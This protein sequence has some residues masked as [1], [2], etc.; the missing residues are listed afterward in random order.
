MVR[1]TWAREV[2][3]V[4]VSQLVPAWH[5]DIAP[6]RGKRIFLFAFKLFLQEYHVMVIRALWSSSPAAELGNLRQVKP[7]PP[8]SSSSTKDG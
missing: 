5:L 4:G 3:S 6:R 1:V 2:Q 7:S 8:S